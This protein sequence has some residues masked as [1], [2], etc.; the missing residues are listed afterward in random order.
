MCKQAAL[1]GAS[2]AQIDEAMDSDDAKQQLI[3]M[4]FQAQSDKVA[5]AELAALEK[6]SQLQTWSMQ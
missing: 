3:E 4:V 1:E 2:K 6:E 5:A